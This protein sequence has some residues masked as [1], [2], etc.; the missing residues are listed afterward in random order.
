MTLDSFGMGPLN[1]RTMFCVIGPPLPPQF[2]NERTYVRV[3]HVWSYSILAR[4]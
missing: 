2:F 4:V 1:V 3:A